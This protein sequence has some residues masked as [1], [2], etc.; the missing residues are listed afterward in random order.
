M[1]QNNAT[2]INTNGATYKTCVKL[3]DTA[4]NTPAYGATSSFTALITAPTCTGATLS[5]D[6]ADG[7]I[8][9]TEHLNTTAVISGASGSSATVSSTKF[10][11]IASTATCDGTQTFA[12]AVPGSN[13]SAFN[14]SGTYKVCAQVSDAV[15]QYGYCASPTITSVKVTITFTSIDRTS[16]QCLTAI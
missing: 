16:D 3:T 14:N 6:A 10:A 13:N 5:G 7:Y 2:A 4:G 11:V 12:S 15:S 8:N 1:P 9:G